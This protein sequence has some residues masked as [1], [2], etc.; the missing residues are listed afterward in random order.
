MNAV[1]VEIYVGRNE[2][3]INWTE[4]NGIR[5]ISFYGNALYL[6]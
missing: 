5:T 6:I 2:T 4:C 1:Y 3:E